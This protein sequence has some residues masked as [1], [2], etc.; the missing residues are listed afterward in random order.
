[1]NVALPLCCVQGPQCRLL[2]A[3]GQET[4]AQGWCSGKTERDFDVATP[5]ISPITLHKRL[6]THTNIYTQTG[7]GRTQKY[8]RIKTHSVNSYSLDSNCVRLFT[9][10]CV[11]THV[12]VSVVPK[13]IPYPEL[14][15]IIPVIYCTICLQGNIV[16]KD[17]WCLQDYTISKGLSDPPPQTMK[18][19]LFN[20]LFI[21]VYVL[22][23]QIY[24][25][26]C[27]LAGDYSKRRLCLP[28][29]CEDVAYSISL[30]LAF[31]LSLSVHLFSVFEC[32]FLS[33]YLCHDCISPSF[34]SLCRWIN[35]VKRWTTQTAPS[36]S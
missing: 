28:Q 6:T 13:S 10:V 29:C 2:H 36:P 22:S 8:R 4:E 20:L 1:M 24:R 30:V 31:S 34:L 5:Q 25:G 15:C 27:I 11:V 3:G 26:I 35:L 17:W 33:F 12:H 32:C 16:F 18:W 21:F 23:P 7:G 14:C 9:G 19:D